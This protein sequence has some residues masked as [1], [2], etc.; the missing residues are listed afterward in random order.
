[1]PLP[2][3]IA[4]AAEELLLAC[5]HADA[6]ELR[7]SHAALTLVTGALDVLHCDAQCCGHAR[8][9]RRIAEAWAMLA[10]DPGRSWT[11]GALARAAGVNER[12][13]K[14]GFRV[15]YGTTVKAALTAARLSAGYDMISE[16]Q[17]R[18]S[19]AARSVGYA[20]PRYFT[21]LFHRR[22]GFAPSGMIR[23]E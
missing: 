11:I 14:V 19:Q 3:R 1:M 7:I 4:A 17:V 21:D 23:G 20:K 13:L 8:D 5:P 15:D 6:G 16:G 18:V 2:P 12:K 22:Y 9:R 10:A